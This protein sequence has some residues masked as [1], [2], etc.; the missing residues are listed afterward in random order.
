MAALSSRLQRDLAGPLLACPTHRGGWID[1]RALVTRLRYWQEQDVPGRTH[2]GGIHEFSIPDRYD[3]IQALLR[4]A[5]DH[6][7]EALRAAADLSGEAGA[8]A[9]FALGGDEP[10]GSSAGPWIAVAR[11]R[12]PHGTF[13]ALTEMHGD[14]GPDAAL[15][16]RYEWEPADPNFQESWKAHPTAQ[17]CVRAVPAVRAEQLAPDRP[18][19][20]LNRL[21]SPYYFTSMLHLRCRAAVWPANPEAPFASGA[22]EIVARLNDP[23][24][25]FSPTAQALDP[26]FD[27]DTPF[28]EMARLVLAV[29]LLCKDAGTRG[30]GIDALV[31]LIEDGR[32]TGNELGPIYGKLASRKDM[33]RLNRLTA[34]LAEAARVSQLHQWVVVRILA[35]TLAA[36][37]LTPPDDL[38]HL[39]SALQEGLLATNQSL[40]AECRPILE[41]ISTSGKTARLARSLLAMR[42]SPG[43]NPHRLAAMNL[44]LAGR[45][46]RASRWSEREGTPNSAP[47]TAS[48]STSSRPTNDSLRTSSID[49]GV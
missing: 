25:S 13:P 40:P 8:A 34:S 24:S 37:G 21:Q 18:L 35:G 12:D 26:L 38:H 16:A 7:A 30:L 46:A 15:P 5:P 20:Y 41:S 42:T 1:P 17:L 11:T 3:F 29:A 44:A 28:S 4:L 14:L 10:I 49:H 23:P 9:R 6:R 22:M 48:T 19:A 33:V 36:L 39:L 45:V 27:P 31:A 47:M 43:P 2:V 32:C